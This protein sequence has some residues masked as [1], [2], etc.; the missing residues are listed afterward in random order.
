M[1]GFDS[2]LVCAVE[3]VCLCVRSSVSWGCFMLFVCFLRF[4]LP[5]GGVGVRKGA[6]SLGDGHGGMA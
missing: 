5:E 3:T 1:W 4:G 6:S 2:I